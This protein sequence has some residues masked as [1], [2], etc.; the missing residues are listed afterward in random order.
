MLKNWCFWTV[1]LEKTLESPLDCKEINQVNPKRNQPWIFIR[2]TDAKAWPHDAESQLIGKDSL[3]DIEG[4]RRKGQQRMRWLGGITISMDM[5]LSKLWEIVKDMEAHYSAVHGVTKSWTQLSNWTMQKLKWM[6]ITVSFIIAITWKQAR[7]PFV[8]EKSNKLLHILT[9]EY[10]SALK[11]T[12]KSWRDLK[13]ILLSQIS[14]S[15]KDTYYSCP[16]TNMNSVKGKTM[17]AVK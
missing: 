16:T 11:W 17:D 4:K 14:Q 13:Y 2:R 15:E 10:Y 6:L 9:K 1:V 5:N 7:Y 3:G 8:D 12:I